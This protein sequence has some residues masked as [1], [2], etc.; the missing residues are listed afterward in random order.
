MV[1]VSHL[2]KGGGEF[3]TP[4]PTPTT[5]V[6][7]LPFGP[8]GMAQNLE[9]DQMRQE[10]PRGHVEGDESSWTHRSQEGS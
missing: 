5:M 7:R 9:V 2:R 1:T 8:Q 10:S 6:S 3:F 4:Q